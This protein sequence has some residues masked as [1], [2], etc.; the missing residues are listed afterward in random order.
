[1]NSLILNRSPS[2]SSESSA[3]GS[4]VDAHERS[5]WTERSSPAAGALDVN[6][7]S[8]P[9]WRN[10]CTSPVVFAIIS[11]GHLQQPDVRVSPPQPGLSTARAYARHHRPQRRRGG[12]VRC[13]SML[14]TQQHSSPMRSAGP[15]ALAVCFA[16]TSFVTRPFQA[17]RGRVPTGTKVQVSVRVVVI[18]QSS[19]RN[20]ETWRK[21]EAGCR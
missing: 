12:L 8:S 6:A 20:G 5:D 9:L 14:Y 1:M 18:I 17:H 11:S 21:R 7:R 10:A 19:M 3:V 16:F 2:K 15:L 4:I 13:S